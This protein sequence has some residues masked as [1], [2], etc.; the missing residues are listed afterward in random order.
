MTADYYLQLAMMEKRLNH[1]VNPLTVDEIRDDLKL[2]FELSNLISQ[3]DDFYS[4]F[5]P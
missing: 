2:R 5:T 4:R 3:G 1:K